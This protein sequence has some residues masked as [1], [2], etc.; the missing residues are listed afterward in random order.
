MPQLLDAS[1]SPSTINDNKNNRLSVNKGNNSKNNSINSY[2][3]KS[4]DADY[5]IQQAEQCK[6][7]PED[8][9]IILCD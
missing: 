5:W 4:Y 9:M 2:R 1:S 7:L 6:Y 3:G 8:E